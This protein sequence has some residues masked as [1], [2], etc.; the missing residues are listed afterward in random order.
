MKP[1]APV[2]AMIGS[3]IGVYACDPGLQHFDLLGI[4]R[5]DIGA[6]RNDPF[7]IAMHRLLPPFAEA[8]DDYDI[9]AGLAARLE[10][11]HP[12]LRLSAADPEDDLHHG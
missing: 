2:S 5:N 12:F 10:R 9:F 6:S 11:C 4:E 7:L 8:K 3:F 1:V